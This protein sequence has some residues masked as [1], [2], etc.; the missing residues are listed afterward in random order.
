MRRGV[1]MIGNGLCFHTGQGFHAPGLS[2]LQGK[3][4]KVTG[5]HHAG[6]PWMAGHGDGVK[7]SEWL[8]PTPQTCFRVCVL[9]AKR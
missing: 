1:V 3:R 4:L 5:R 6:L 9:I 7:Q 8:K 2:R